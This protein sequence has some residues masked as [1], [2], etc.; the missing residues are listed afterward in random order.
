MSHISATRQ[1]WAVRDRKSITQAIAVH[2]ST[3]LVAALI[4]AKSPIVGKSGF[5]I[6]WLFLHLITA[7]LLGRFGR[8]RKTVAN[9]ILEVGLVASVLVVVGA[10]SSINDW[11]RI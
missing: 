1:P 4:V 7:T 2:I 8:K 11:S 6:T 5:V 10:A 9:S 3:P